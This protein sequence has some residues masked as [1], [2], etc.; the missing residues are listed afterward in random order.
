MCLARFVIERALT[1]PPPGQRALES[2]SPS[3]RML[4]LSTLILRAC[5]TVERE[6]KS[7]VAESDNPPVS[8]LKCCALAFCAPA[9]FLT[10]VVL[11]NLLQ[12]EH[13]VPDLRPLQAL[14]DS[15]NG[16][17]DEDGAANDH[18][19]APSKT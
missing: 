2:Y 4:N 16:S 9:L 12:R 6:G 5:S 19:T 13:S 8:Q 18:Q 15:E 3:A 11:G 1:E 10:R 17:D 14:Q 7:P